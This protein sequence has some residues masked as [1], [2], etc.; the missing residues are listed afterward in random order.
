MP[1][2]VLWVL[3]ATLVA[4][5]C[6]EVTAGGGNA[7]VASVRVTPT[8]AQLAP[9]G[10]VAFNATALEADGDPIVGRPVT[11]TIGN[12]AV[13]SVS[14]GGMVTGEAPGSTTVT[15]TV[16][17]KAG[18]GAVVVSAGA[19]LSVADDFERANGPLG[20]NWLDLFDNLEIDNGEV[21]MKT[22]A[23]TS[24]ARW[25]ANTFGPN[26]FSEVVV[27]SLDGNAFDF[28][29]GLQAFVR[30]QQ[31]GTP[32]RWGFHYFSDNTTYGIKYDGGPTAE[33]RTWE[34]G[35]EP[36]PVPGDVLRIEAIG[37]TIRGFLNGQLKVQ[38]ID[39]ALDNGAIGFVVGLNPGATTLPRG[40]VAAWSGGER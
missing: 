3:T 13:A 30:Q 5:A 4:S 9:G 18:Q 24:P 34:T 12:P 1:R 6:G 17:G 32:W 14:L 25:Q 22:L 11:W 33:T 10:Q 7:V 37:D 19:T 23:G 29:R 26:Q 27:G 16:D 35:P 38:V 31:T 28:F 21:G 40:I 36:L 2:S 39:G 15:A 8:S 20:S